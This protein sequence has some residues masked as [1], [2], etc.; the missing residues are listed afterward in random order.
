MRIRVN[1]QTI[2][3]EMI[4]REMD[5]LRAEHDRTFQH[6]PEDQREEQLR[7]W[8]TE[9]VI[10]HVLLAQEARR[11]NFP[12]DEGIVAS[13]FAELTKNEKLSEQEKER[14]K[15][16]LR[17]EAQIGQLMQEVQKQVTAPTNEELQK[18]YQEH[19]QEFTVAERVNA[20]HI[21]V[22]ITAQQSKVQAYKKISEIKKRLDAGESFETLAQTMGE[23][24][25]W[26]L[27]WFS[28]GKMVE[29]FEDAVFA[30]KPGEIS[31]II[32]TEYGYHIARVYD[33]QP[34]TVV[35]FENVKPQIEKRLS[36][37]KMQEKIYELIDRLKAEATIVEEKDE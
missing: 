31:D 2:T 4:Q 17:L 12:V 1:D 30:L 7:K 24:K 19:I 26:R 28:R 9:N 3:E 11:R 22:Y 14:L 18:Y 29:A 16:D 25:D 32:L 6:L 37:E 5:R 35:P 13:R 36:F 23:C 27:G 33:Y 15:E 21:V 8:S 20:A 10:E 34:Q